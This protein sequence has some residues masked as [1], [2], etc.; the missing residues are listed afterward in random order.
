M[1]QQMGPL[2]AD[3]PGSTILFPEPQVWDQ[4][5]TGTLCQKQRPPVLHPS[6]ASYKRC[7][8]TFT[9]SSVL[10]LNKSVSCQTAGNAPL[11]TCGTLESLSCPLGVREPEVPE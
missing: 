1:N 7:P 3:A 10:H 5:Q 2:S 9:A 6:P 11:A 4:S 8:L